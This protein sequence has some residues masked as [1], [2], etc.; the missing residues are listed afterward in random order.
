MVMLCD[1][2][3]LSTKDSYFERITH[4]FKRTHE[5][6]VDAIAKQLELHA[7]VHEVVGLKIENMS[8]GDSTNLGAL[9]L[10]KEVGKKTE[11]D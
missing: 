7:A 6:L 5:S 8:A 4:A 3:I 11:R 1:V 9:D 2:K 10:A